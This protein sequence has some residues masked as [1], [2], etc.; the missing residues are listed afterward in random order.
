LIEYLI[1]SILYRS[2]FMAKPT[3][4]SV[5]LSRAKEN[6]LYGQAKPSPR[7]FLPGQAKPTKFLRL[8][9]PSQTNTSGLPRS[10]QTPPLFL[11]RSIFQSFFKP[12]F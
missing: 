12:S 10:G 6:F 2:F 5:L 3:N 1:D 11:K 4:F 7:N 8:V 9:K